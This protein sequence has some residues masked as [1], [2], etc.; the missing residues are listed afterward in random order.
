MAS[1]EESLQVNRQ[2]TTPF[3]LKLFYRQNSFHS[4]SDFPVPSATPTDNTASSA[5]AP[6]PPHLQIYTWQS[7]SLREL[8]HLLTSALPTLLPDPA[9]GTRLSFRLVYPDTRSQAGSRPGD[10]GDGRGKYVSKDIGSVIVG[11]MK[12]GDGKDGDADKAGEGISLEGD[13]ADKVL[14]DARF[15]IGDYIDCAILP[16]LADGSVAPAISSRGPLHPTMGRGMRAFG[17]GPFSRDGGFS[18]PR[19]GPG[20]PSGRNGGGVA[21]SNLANVPSGEWRRGERLPDSGGRVY[22]RGSRDGGGRPY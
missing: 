15:V 19:H 9:V 18:R 1:T 13:E 11:F 7:C 17:G 16:P 6:L 21:G 5:S 2:K 8:A 4:L 10:G 14:H 12:G 22:S 3:H 20:A